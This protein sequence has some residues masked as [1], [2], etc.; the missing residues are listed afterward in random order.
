MSVTIHYFNNGYTSVY[1]DGQLVADGNT[2]QVQAFARNV[3]KAA[4]S[5]VVETV[6]GGLRKL[7]FSA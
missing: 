6:N 5:P 1:S 7:T 4:T 3:V 2:S